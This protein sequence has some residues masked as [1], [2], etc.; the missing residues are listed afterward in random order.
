MR[1]IILGFLLILSC[2]PGIGHAKHPAVRHYFG[3]STRVTYYDEG[4]ITAS[5]HPVFYGEVAA[6]YWVP[7][8]SH[9]V[10]PGLGTFQVLDRGLLG[11]NQIDVYEPYVGY[12]RI[13]DWYRGVYWWSS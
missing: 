13:N 2:C 9:V 1:G 12:R 8:Y 6:P 5:G 7:L 3:G 10:I 4:Y 11:S